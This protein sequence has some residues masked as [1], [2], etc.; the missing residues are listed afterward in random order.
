MDSKPFQRLEQIRLKNINNRNWINQDLYKFLY[1]PDMYISA[2]ENIKGNK[3]ALTKGTTSDTLDGFSLQRINQLVETMRE[4]KFEFNP[5]RRI[6]I[7]KPGKNTLRPLGIA[8][9][10][11]K[12]VQEIIRMILEAIYEPT[13]SENSHGFRPNRSCHTALQQV[14]QQFNGTK[15]LIEGDIQGAYDTINH[16]ILLKLLRRRVKDERFIQLIHKA[17]K[18]GYIE[19]TVPILSLIGTPQG[20]IVS[21]ILANIYFH[22]LDCFVESLQSEYTTKIEDR[23]RRSTKIY[24][25]LAMSVSKVETQLSE[26]SDPV[27]RKQLAKKLRQLKRQR[28]SIKAYETE[29]I[30]IVIRYVR[31][32][33]DW[34]LGVN[35]P[36]KIAEQIKKQVT[37]FLKKQLQLTLSAEKTKLTYLKQEKGLFLGYEIRLDSMVRTV[38]L[39]TASNKTYYKRTTGNFVKLDAPLGRIISRLCAKGFCDSKGK[40]LSKGSWTVQEDFKIVQSYNSILNGLMNYYSGADN[41]RKLIR[42]QYILQ[43]SCACTLAQKHKSSVK[44]I[45]TLHGKSLCVKHMVQAVNKEVVKE[46]YLNLRKFNKNRKKWLVRLIANDPFKVYI[47]RR[48]RSKISENCCICGSDQEVQ[49]HHI[50]SVKHAKNTQ[51]FAQIMGLINRKQIPVCIDC[52]N[53]IHSGQY[54]GLKLSD[55]VLPNLAKK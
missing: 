44:K 25:Q 14:S 37:E 12:L 33:D 30:P 22:E 7:P 4:N 18:A 49:M 8:N 23:K 35:G 55:F 43:H 41:G 36:R 54:D 39:K 47:N 28:A 48:T 10:T 40:P 51:G 13:F 16:E 45:Y 27:E 52:H 1:K 53:S 20:S 17:L 6:L 21:P 24:N 50:K 9:A 32:A 15:W 11:D 46:V 3:G 29:S 19:K 38:K 26:C 2:Y 34:I 5:A 31:Y 42:I